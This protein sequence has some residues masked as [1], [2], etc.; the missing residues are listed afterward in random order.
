MLSLVI[1]GRNVRLYLVV[2]QKITVGTKAMYN[3]GSQ[4][5]IPSCDIDFEC[6]ELQTPSTSRSESQPL[7]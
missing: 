1:N 3:F 5:D 6:L 4:S 7:D 2:Q